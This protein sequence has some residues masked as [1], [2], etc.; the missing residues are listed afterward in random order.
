M[1]YNDQFSLLITVMLELSSVL[2]LEKKIY[3]A[4]SGPDEI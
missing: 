1:K 4:V 2:C 3:S